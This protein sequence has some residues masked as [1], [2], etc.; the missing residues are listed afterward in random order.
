MRVAFGALKA[1]EKMLNDW[2]I[3]EPFARS[4]LC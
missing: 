3:A 4:V 2:F 1:V